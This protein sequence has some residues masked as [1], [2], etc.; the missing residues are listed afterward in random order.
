MKPPPLP[1]QAAPK[2]SCLTVAL[3]VAGIVA[4]VLVGGV[5]LAV[6]FAGKQRQAYRA[7]IEEV[8]S[9]RVKLRAEC[10]RPIHPVLKD[11]MLDFRLYA[12]GLKKIDASNCPKDF[13][14]AWVDYVLAWDRRGNYGIFDLSRDAAGITTGFQTGNFD[15]T[16]KRADKRDSEE[17]WRGVQRIAA[18]YGVPIAE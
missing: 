8:L 2:I 15:G 5:A 11:K 13:R 7:A 9:D 1:V 12:A 17:A 3:I 16:L 4:A 18:I 10:T 6:H 14:V